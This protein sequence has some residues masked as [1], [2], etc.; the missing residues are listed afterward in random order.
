MSSF[1][2][3]PITRDLIHAK[4]RGATIPESAYGFE[5][6]II[7]TK[8]RSPTSPFLKAIVITLIIL[9]ILGILYLVWLWFIRK[10]GESPTDIFKIFTGD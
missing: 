9:L 10:E 5:S 3:D 8:R 2:Y 1:T 6:P 7:V 4:P